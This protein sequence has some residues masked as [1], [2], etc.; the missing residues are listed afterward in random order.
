VAQAAPIISWRRPKPLT[1]HAG[2][3][4][5][6][7]GM[8]TRLSYV[9]RVGFHAINVCW[10]D[11]FIENFFLFLSFCFFFFGFLCVLFCSFCCVLFYFVLFCSFLF[12]FV[13]FVLYFLFVL[14]VLLCLVD[15]FILF[16]LCMHIFFH[17]KFFFLCQVHEQRTRI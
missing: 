8:Q 15:L 11:V 2:C 16:V 13:C 12:C 9:P 10:D 7:R 1:T 17:F 14:F 6:Q 3:L 4:P 5:A